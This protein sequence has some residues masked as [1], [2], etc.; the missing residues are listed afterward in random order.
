MELGEMN[1]PVATR[2]DYMDNVGTYGY[3]RTPGRSFGFV[4]E[5]EN[6]P[7]KKEKND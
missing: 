4:I 3:A 7:L 2:R 1:F 5:Y 6:K